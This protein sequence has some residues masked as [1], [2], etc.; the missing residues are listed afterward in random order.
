MGRGRG[1]L[2]LGCFS[3]NDSKTVCDRTGFETV[4]SKTQETWQGWVVIPESWEARQPQDFPV[5]A[6][7]Q[8]VY[9]DSRSEQ[10]NP[11]EEAI[12]FPDIV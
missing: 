7:K 9:K 11:S 6:E 3:P 10:A 12:P 5:T 4:L 2:K 1:Y 8:Q